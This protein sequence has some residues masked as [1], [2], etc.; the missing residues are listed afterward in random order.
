MKQNVDHDLLVEGTFPDIVDDDILQQ[1][2]NLARKRRDLVV[3]AM[4]HIW[5]NYEYSR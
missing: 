1:S 5:E 3:A 2:D 4:K